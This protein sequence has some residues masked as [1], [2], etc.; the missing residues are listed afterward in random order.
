M[1]FMGFG[2][3][4][5]PG[6]VA[7]YAVVYKGGHPDYPTAKSGQID[8]KI[9]QDRFELSP[10]FGSK[11]WFKHLLISYNTVSDLQ[12]V[13]RQV[14]TFEGVLGGLDSR[15]LNQRNNIHI[16]Y[17]GG[18]DA[19]IVLRLEML[20]GLSV[21][22]QARKCREL[23][24]R[25]RIHKIRQH[26]RRPRSERPEPQQVTTDIPTQIEKL[27]ELRDRG[28]ISEGEFQAKKKDLLARM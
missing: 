25:L 1:G 7:E 9:F 5:E 4:D 21:M 24:D 19:E 14:S 3:K 18:T 10:T 17:Q 11:S 2:V 20:S 23:E 8:L 26:F 22:G 27:A 6:K 13:E 12:I 28:L 15:Q 16:T